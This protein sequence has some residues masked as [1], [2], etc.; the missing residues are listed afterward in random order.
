VLLLSQVLTYMQFLQS[1]KL[2]V[3]GQ[4]KSSIVKKIPQKYYQLYLN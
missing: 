1:V 3:L 2:K 4:A